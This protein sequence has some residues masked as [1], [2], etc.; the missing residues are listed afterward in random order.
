MN[1]VILMMVFFLA[2]VSYNCQS[3]T[4]IYSGRYG[5]DTMVHIDDNVIYKGRYGYDALAHIDNNV[6]Y[7]GRY[8][9]DALAHVDDRVIYKERYGYDAIAHIDGYLSDMQ[10]FAVLILILNM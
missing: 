2:Q 3:Q 9:Y 1:R 6:I 10:L 5:Y 4:V 8:G 7:K